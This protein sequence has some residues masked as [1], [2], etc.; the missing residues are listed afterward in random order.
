MTAIFTRFEG[1][2]EKPFVTSIGKPS[3]EQARRVPARVPPP[4]SLRPLRY[5]SSRTPF[6]L[7][8]RGRNMDSTALFG[9]SLVLLFATAPPVTAWSSEFESNSGF[10]GLTQTLSDT[11][12]ED[13]SGSDAQSP[14][15]SELEFDAELDFVDAA[16]VD[17]AGPC[18]TEK[19]VVYPQGDVLLTTKTRTHGACCELCRSDGDCFSWYR[20]ARTGRCILNKNVPSAVRKGRNFAGG[21]NF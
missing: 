16:S 4:S 7:R 11:S 18:S 8:A 9:V 2:T 14:Q 6:N 13:G 17:S 10:R 5:A 19:G 1:R 20:N 3:L 12:P 15:S 21:S